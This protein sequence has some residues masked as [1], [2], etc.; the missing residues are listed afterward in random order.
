MAFAPLL[1]VPAGQGLQEEGEEASTY[2][3]EEHDGPP[4]P[5]ELVQEVEPTLSEK[6]PLGQGTQAEREVADRAVE[7]VFLGQG[8]GLPEPAGQ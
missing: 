6:K 1:A 4:L 3:P 8:V 7:A 5:P 2:V